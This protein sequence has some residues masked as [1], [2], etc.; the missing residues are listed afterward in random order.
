M[1]T[2]AQLLD[3]GYKVA[4]TDRI[5]Q[6]TRDPQM[7]VISE[8]IRMA[9]E[10]DYENWKDPEMKRMVTKKMLAIYAMMDE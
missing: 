9:V 4:R 2:V 1:I 3:K 6:W 8:N 5:F 7:N 10:R